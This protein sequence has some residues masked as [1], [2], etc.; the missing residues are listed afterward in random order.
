[1]SDLPLH[2][3]DSTCPVDLFEAVPQLQHLF[4]ACESCI[5]EYYRI[6]GG[7]EPLNGRSALQKLSAKV[8]ARK[9]VAIYDAL[10]RMRIDSLLLWLDF[11]V[12]F[13]SSDL[14]PSFSSASCSA[15]MSRTFRSGL[16]MLDGHI[17]FM[18]G[19]Q[20]GSAV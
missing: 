1:M 16:E 2:A 6:A 5:D 7:K 8:L 12:S 3:H 11:D 13:K 20:W 17:S 19:R 14:D 4:T 18:T 15:S 10:Q 9:V